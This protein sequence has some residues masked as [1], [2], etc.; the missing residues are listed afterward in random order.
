MRSTAAGTGPGEGETVLA[1]AFDNADALRALLADRARLALLDEATE[2]IGTSL[3]LDVTCAELARFAVPRFADLASVEILP[4][5]ALPAGLTVGAGPLRVRRTALEA[6]PGLRH[7]METLAPA[8]EWVR[9]LPRC[10]T[11]QC[12]ESGQAFL[13][14][15]RTGGQGAGAGEDWSCELGGGVGAASVLVVPLRAGGR[16]IGVLS[17]LRSPPS[18]A[19]D[20]DAAT[21]QAVA[22]RAARSM[23]NARRYAVAQD[24]TMELQGALLADPGS[25]HANLELASRYLPC[26]TSA[27][28]G[29]DWFET[30]RL[31]FGR[32]LLVIGDVM[33]HGVETAV[34]M[35]AYRMLL[36]YVA[37]TDLPPHRILRQLDHLTSQSDATRPATCLLA[38]VEP[39]RHRCTFASAGHPPPT[40]LRPDGPAELL[41]VPTGPPLGTGLGEYQAVV[42]SLDPE[43]MLLLYTDG[44]VERRTEDIDASLARLTRLRRPR[45][46]ESLEDLLDHVL[47]T[48]APTTPDDDIAVLA[49]R[50]HEQPGPQDVTRAG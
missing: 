35:N 29:G 27:M 20:D 49:A 40:L 32:T 17:L 6:V 4:P 50:V 13:S 39:A 43:Q 3:D 11:A 2:Q 30:I 38:L 41:A 22:D 37:A 47:T 5:E 19:F 24:L 16:L 7:G 45:P 34:D 21:V 14:H 9:H 25:P 42:H 28:V 10:P 44:L 46:G 1:S 36:R 18:A 26:G 12:L 31:S 33:G 23:D 15:D 48:V 8:A